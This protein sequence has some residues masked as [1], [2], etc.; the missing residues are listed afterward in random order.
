M[1][2][3]CGESKSAT[4]YYRISRRSVLPKCSSKIAKEYKTSRKK[5]T[6]EVR[7]SA[8]APKLVLM[9]EPHLLLCSWT[10]STEL[11]WTNVRCECG[12]VWSWSLMLKWRPVT[13]SLPSCLISTEDAIWWQASWMTYK[14]FEWRFSTSQEGARVYVSPP[15]TLALASP[16]RPE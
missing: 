15:L 7:K 6:M 10:Q 14:I 4:R 5:W 12:C 9:L 16:W 1:Y 8:G 2:K 3:S 11:G 13:Y